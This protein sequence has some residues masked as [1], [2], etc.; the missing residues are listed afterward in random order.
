MPS[1]WPSELDAFRQ[2]HPAET[3]AELTLV[4]P[5]ELGRNYVLHISKNKDLGL[6]VPYVCVRT[7]KDEDRTI[8]RVSTAPSIAACLIGYDTTIEEWM[9]AQSAT[10]GYGKSTVPWCGG[11]YIYA[12]PFQYA[13]KPSA[14][15]LKNVVATDEHW[16]VSYGPTSWSYKPIK[17]GKIFYTAVTH[18]AEGRSKSL[19]IDLCVEITHPNIKVPFCHNL[20]LEAGYYR[21]Q[22][23]K[24]LDMAAFED[25][26]LDALQH[27]T[28]E[29]YDAIKVPAAA[30]LSFTSHAVLP[31]HVPSLHW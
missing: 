18:Q 24:L 4:T 2:V 12:I 31:E 5:Q 9:E 26:A 20:K 23:D 29:E 27:L 22:S 13:F 7:Q 17:V 1:Q 10:D 19:M 28:K 14:K 25:V 16:L 6:M 8:P 11:W 21:I 15:L 3:V 30:M